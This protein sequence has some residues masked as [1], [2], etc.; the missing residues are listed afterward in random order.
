MTGIQKY[1]SSFALFLMMDDL[2]PFSSVI[3]F[4]HLIKSYGFTWKELR[5]K[6]N[7]SPLRGRYYVVPELYSALTICQFISI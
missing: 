2:L 4:T 6:D 3:E 7:K 5:M 1:M